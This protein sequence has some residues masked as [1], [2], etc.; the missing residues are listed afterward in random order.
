MPDRVVNLWGSKTQKWYLSSII[1]GHR[2]WCF[3]TPFSLSE[4]LT[5]EVGFAV[6][7]TLQ[8]ETWRVCW[9]G[10]QH[11]VQQSHMVNG[12]NCH[13]DMDVSP[14]ADW[15]HHNGW[16]LTSLNINQSL[17]V[18]LELG[19]LIFC[20]HQLS[21]ACKGLPDICNNKLIIM[22]FISK[23]VDPEKL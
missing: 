2:R 14:S 8:L 3:Y 1:G 11:S 20:E 22:N 13:S 9:W 15:F 10:H 6:A 17:V 21:T 16:S 4:D 5:E 7:V 18:V 19:E 12:N 23:C